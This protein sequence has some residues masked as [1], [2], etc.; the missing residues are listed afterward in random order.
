MLYW[1]NEN[2]ARTCLPRTL[3]VAQSLESLQLKQTPRTARSLRIT[4]SHAKD[5]YKKLRNSTPI[6]A[7]KNINDTELNY[8]SRR[9]HGYKER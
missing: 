4:H 2:A 1:V 8:S 9:T 5:Q 3:D 6:I 7:N